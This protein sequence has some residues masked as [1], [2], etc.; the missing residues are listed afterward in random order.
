MIILSL[1][2][3]GYVNISMNKITR[4]GVK[5]AAD[6]GF[7]GDELWVSYRL[8]NRGLIP[9]GPIEIFLVY[10]EHLRLSKGSRRAL[11]MI[12]PKGCVIYKAAFEAR[13]GRH[14]IGPLRIVVR[15]PLGLFRSDEID[16]GEPVELLVL[17]RLIPSSLRSSLLLSRSLGMARSRISGSGTE[18]L[19]V[20]EYREGDEPRRIVW[21]HTARWGKLI[22][23]ETEKEASGNIFYI[24]LIAG[25]MF[26]G[27]YR[28]TPFENAA[29]IIATMSRYSAARGDAMFLALYSRETIDLVGP[30]RGLGGYRSILSRM[31]RI[32]FSQ[33]TVVS[34]IDPRPLAKLLMRNLKGGDIV[35]LFTAP[36]RDSSA[37]ATAIERIERSVRNA[38]GS[39]YT[40]I[41]TPSLDLARRLDLG[42][43]IKLMEMIKDSIALAKELRGRGVKAIN[44][45]QG[46]IITL[47]RLI[48]MTS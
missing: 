13:T 1:V 2:L 24:L 25:D 31:A 6:R 35:L 41:P 27:P 23:K 38:G 26:T 46:K 43:K 3:M 14:L 19:S 8:C 39:F 10:P 18:F 7:E 40:V 12:P 9:I 20:R 4:S 37:I 44:I 17:P 28:E 32:S 11:I 30:S 15:D 42:S 34:D 48:E 22:V 45:S 29:R 47:T 5:G 36:S 33:D 16:V 21:R